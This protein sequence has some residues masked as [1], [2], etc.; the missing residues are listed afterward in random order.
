MQR[1]FISLLL[2]LVLGF[3]KAQSTH[4]IDNLRTFAKI[5]GLVKYYYPGDE[6]ANLDWDYFAILG[7]EKVRHAKSS[8]ELLQLL[9][10][11]FDPIAPGIDIRNDDGED[12]WPIPLKPEKLNCHQVFYTDASIGIND[13]DSSNG[14]NSF[15][16]RTFRKA[17]SYTGGDS[18][19][20]FD[21]P[22]KVGSYR[23][24]NCRLSLCMINLTPRQGAIECSVSVG[25]S[26][27]VW[28]QNS[29][30]YIRSKAEWQTFTAAG[31]IPTN[32]RVLSIKMFL[33]GYV[34][35]NLDDIIVEV[36]T[37]TGWKKIYQIDFEGG[38][39]DKKCWKNANDYSNATYAVQPNIN[40][41]SN[42]CLNISAYKSYASKIGKRNKPI[43]GHYELLLGDYS[44]FQIGN[45]LRVFIPL[46]LWADKHN[47][48][49]ISNKQSLDSLMQEF[50]MLEDI[51]GNNLIVRQA[52]VINAWNAIEYHFLDKE[53]SLIHWDSVLTASLSQCYGDQNEGEFVRVLQ[54]MMS[55]LTDH[56]IQ[57]L[58]QKRNLSIV[59]S[60]ILKIESSTIKIRFFVL[61][62]GYVVYDSILIKI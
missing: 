32:A 11:L 34:E 48:Y 20:L 21:I 10:E 62:G 52:N 17:V 1:I 49:P 53:N 42:S 12:F 35:A 28:A 37:K 45:N 55:N 15:S 23:G 39:I 59:E 14:L 19:S 7:V 22:L 18:Y 6:A 31:H 56:N 9:K 46:K 33:R 44:W 26:M 4:E 58:H 40:R 29:K 36:E 3:S 16:Q 8:D 25:D 51:S 5:Y 30:T 47:T 60:Q 24:L 2:L 54:Q 41:Q 57:V 61:P 38:N 27:F 13:F 50:R 43:D